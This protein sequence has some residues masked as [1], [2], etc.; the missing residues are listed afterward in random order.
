MRKET[1]DIAQS[2]AWR[3]DRLPILCAL[4][5]GL[6]LPPVSA[7]EDSRLSVIVYHDA[8]STVQQ[9]VISALVAALAREASDRFDLQLR[10]LSQSPSDTDPD[11]Q[12]RVA[13]GSVAARWLARR[14]DRIPRL[15]ALLPLLTWR[16][17]QIC[18][19]PALDRDAALLIDRPFNQQL[20]L[21]KAV[22]PS[23]G[24]LGVL[25]GPGS[26]ALAEDL[27]A[28]AESQGV[29]LIVRR[30]EDADAVGPAL[31]DIAPDVDVL[32]ALPDV[33]VFN[34]D[35]LYGILLA[36]YSANL[37]LFGYSEAMVRAGAAAALHLTPE[38]AGSDLAFAIRQFALS[39][40]LD[41]T[42]PSP[43]SSLAVNR[44]VLRSL[45]IDADALNW[46]PTPAASGE[47]E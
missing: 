20:E 32:L 19:E 14:E 27:G 12:L 3:L 11:G 43:S 26:Q 5:F 40:R 38:N 23:V 22:V 31:R 9:R 42:G 17:I 39:G 4:L 47:R 25:I 37:P 13:I 6:L 18:C 8:A 33:V 41:P 34:G 16:D 29:A 10:D 35:T 7:A 1:P 46:S 44:A 36:S 2:V 24:R 45:G 21:I 28:A 15:Y 30:V